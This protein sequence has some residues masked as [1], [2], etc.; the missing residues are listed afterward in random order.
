[1]EYDQHDKLC[2]ITNMKVVIQYTIH[3]RTA[4]KCRTWS[5]DIRRGQPVHIPPADKY[6]STTCW[7]CAMIA[8]SAC[9]QPL[10]SL[11]GKNGGTNTQVQMC[12]R[13]SFKTHCNAETGGQNVQVTSQPPPLPYFSPYPQLLGVCFETQQPPSLPDTALFMLPSFKEN[14]AYQ[15]Q[16]PTGLSSPPSL[17][18]TM[19]QSD[20]TEDNQPTLLSC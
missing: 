8:I 18:F 17:T 9:A 3:T 2:C 16:V 1:M 7:L 13:C 20:V 10:Q 11:T 14:G 6:V 5:N 12:D 19:K 4:T 15:E